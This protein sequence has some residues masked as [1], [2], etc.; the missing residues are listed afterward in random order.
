V[1]LHTDSSLPAQATYFA[2]DDVRRMFKQR[3]DLRLE[4]LSPPA[5]GSR[6]WHATIRDPFGVILRIA[7]RMSGDPAATSSASDRPEK[8]QIDRPRLND[9]YMRIGRT[10]DDLPYTAQFEELYVDYVEPFSDE[11][12]S[13]SEV[14]RHL[15]ATRKAGKLAKLGAARSKPPELSPADR[16]LL[17]QLLGQDIGKRDRLPYAD[18]FEV[19]VEAFNRGRRQ[20][21]TPH[22]IWRAVATL[23]K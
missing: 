19:L 10:A 13:R 2:V 21:V 22:Q 16:E 15:L 6:G 17:I 8:F 5:S 3:R 23:A 18:R 20:H 7:D 9:I 14:W 11:K 4:F 12:P 1:T